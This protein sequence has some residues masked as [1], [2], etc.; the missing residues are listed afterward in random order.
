MTEQVS[1]RKKRAD[2]RKH[3]LVKIMV[4]GEGSH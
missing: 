1:Q 3:P 2:I 4:D